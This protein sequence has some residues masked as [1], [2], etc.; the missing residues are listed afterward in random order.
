[1]VLCVFYPQLFPHQRFGISGLVPYHQQ[2]QTFFS[3]GPF[4]GERIFQNVAAVAY[5]LTRINTNDAGVGLGAVFFDYCD[6]TE[7]A[8]ERV[9]NFFSG[10]AQE[11]DSSLLLGPGRIVASVSLDDDAAEAV[12]NILA[13]N[14]IPHFSSPVGGIRLAD[15]T[16]HSILT[17]VPSRTAELR[18]L[19]A[20]AKSFDWT[21]LSVVYDNDADGRFLME[22]FRG[23]AGAEDMCIGDSLGVPQRVSEEYARQV[24]E[25]LAA[26]WKPR[27]VVLLMDAADNI[28][29]LLQ[30]AERLGHAEHFTFLAGPAWG[31]KPG[32]SGGL[33]RVSA[34]AITLTTETYDLPDF[35]AFVANLTLEHHSPLP[36]E[37]FE[38]YFQHK[39]ECRLSASSRVQRQ[40]VRECLGTENTHADDLVQDP[41]V[42]HTVLAINA[43]AHGLD[44]Y[45]TRHCA[46]ATTI[47][48][49]EVVQAELLLEVQRQSRLTLNNTAG[50]GGADAYGYHLW[51]YRRLGA[52]YGY[53]S[54]GGWQNGVLRMDKPGLEFK[55]G[56]Y[57]PDSRCLA[58]ACLEVCAPQSAV[59]AAMALPK[60]LPIDS[61]FHTVYG[62][63]TA[64]L[65]L[66]GVVACLACLIYLMATFPPAA[67]APV[68]GCLALAGC[69]MVYAANFAFIFQPTEG[70]CAVRRLLPGVAYAL[71]YAA[72]LVKALHACR[73]A[74]AAARDNASGNSGDS[75]AKSPLLARVCGQLVVTVALVVVQVVLAVA[76]LTLYPPEVDLAGNSWQCAPTED[77]EAELV[78]SLAYVMVLLAAT[79][80]LCLEAWHSGAASG[81]TRW[82]LAAS[83]CSIISWCVWTVAATQ[84]PRHLR[85]PA[86]VIGNLVSASVVLVILMA[87]TVTLYTQFNQDVKELEMRS[88]YTAATSLCNAS[89]SAHKVPP[90]GTPP[91]L[92]PG[93]DLSTPGMPTRQFVGEC[94]ASHPSWLSRLMGLL[95]YLITQCSFPSLVLPILSHSSACKVLLE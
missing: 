4:A 76:W 31:N 72:L 44:A 27:V 67:G 37:W 11:G 58:G 79:A 80:A 91:H 52:D 21:F 22:T 42:F 48:D 87:R 39:F 26:G 6:R 1:M 41:F 38:E 61:N 13:A 62:I 10:E 40:F 90:D 59:Y 45:L 83:L 85:D 5:A 9:F 8:R 3:C 18:A 74:A 69:L 92:P 53:V 28:R 20:A 2:G 88:H 95:M 70:T 24:V 77:F 64:V 32:V 93:L 34:G 60:P 29:T 16:D 71:V 75:S 23:M 17:S 36:D 55:I 78:T 57:P 25:T 66:L 63:T 35:R 14:H 33:D 46:D 94:Q 86:M 19:L 82:V 12:S 84:A 56:G 73:L 30:V 54:A 7:R 47:E 81:E 49:C 50:H 89:L 15:R 51:N 43:V 65:S 68:L